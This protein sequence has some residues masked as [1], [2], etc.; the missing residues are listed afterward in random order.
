MTWLIGLTL[1]ILAL[2]AAVLALA[3]RDLMTSVV[4]L[5]IFSFIMAILY[6]AFGAVDVAFNEA[7]IGAGISG[8]FFVLTIFLTTRKSMD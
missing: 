2:S 8:V 7:V 3:V 5:T 4:S 6:A 1:F